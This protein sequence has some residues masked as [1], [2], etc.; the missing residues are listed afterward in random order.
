MQALVFTLAW[1]ATCMLQSNAKNTHAMTA[2]T[3]VFWGFF[4]AKLLCWEFVSIGELWVFVWGLEVSAANF[5]CR[6]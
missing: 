1:C 5:F 6:L 3:R 2:H 4:F